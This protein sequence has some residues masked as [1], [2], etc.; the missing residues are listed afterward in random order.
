MPKK[1]VGK[2]KL[3]ADLLEKY[4]EAFDAIDADGAGSID[5]AELTYILGGDEIGDDAIQAALAKF[6][7]DKDGTMDKDEYFDFVYGS[8]LEQARMFLKEADTSGDGKLSKGELEG[9]FAKLGFPSDQADAAMASAD[10]DGS[11][12]LSIDEIVDYLLEV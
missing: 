10:D 9:V 2:S 7:T 4:G 11:G 8:M 1:G 5:K 3:S 12:T 6:D